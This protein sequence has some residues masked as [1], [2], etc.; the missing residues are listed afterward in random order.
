MVCPEPD[1]GVSNGGA[2]TWTLCLYVCVVQEYVCTLLR[3]TGNKTV[4][5][6]V[7][8]MIQ[9]KM[10]EIEL[11]TETQTDSHKYTQTHANTQRQTDDHSNQCGLQRMNGVLCMVAAL[12][13]DR[14]EFVS[15]SV[16]G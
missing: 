14:V 15:H 6:M 10:S 1:S 5:M 2:L 8:L 4:T 9:K 7:I 13:L 11:T 3:N 16:S 12:L